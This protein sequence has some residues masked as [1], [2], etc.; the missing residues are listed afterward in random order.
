MTYPFFSIIIISHNQDYCIGN[1][2]NSCL[3]QRF[4]DFE[5]IIVDDYSTDKTCDLLET[6][7]SRYSCIKTVFHSENLSSHVARCSGVKK[8]IGKY[9]LFLDGDDTLHE[10]VLHKLHEWI[11]SSG[12]FDVCEFAYKRCPSGEIVLPKRMNADISR[13]DS[14]K[15]DGIS[16]EVWNKVYESRM[17]KTSVNAMSEV[18]LNCGDDV[19]ESIC[20]AY[21]TKIFKQIDIVGVDYNIG[22]GIST[23]L[24]TF[25]DNLNNIQSM[26][27]VL[28]EISNFIQSIPRIDPN[29]FYKARE[30]TAVSWLSRRIYESTRK[31]DSCKSFIALIQSFSPESCEAAFSI[32]YEK[33]MR[34]DSGDIPFRKIIKRFIPGWIK[35]LLGRR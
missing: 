21:F 14:F 23:K 25:E 2:I 8:S 28:K 26:K 15:G 11:S 30:R 20:I 7:E 31:E 12:K 17:L 16:F 1:A 33:S 27:N 34:Y 3:E 10:D 9:I 24:H 22:E 32:I 6:Y 4:K 13:F 18:Y 19:Y 5:I 35:R 29:P